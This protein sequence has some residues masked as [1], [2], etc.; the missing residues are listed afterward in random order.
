MS[1]KE[2]KLIKLVLAIRRSG[3]DIEKIYNEEVLNDD[4][5]S[6]SKM[7]TS[8]NKTSRM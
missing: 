2:S 3:V 4:S 1:D 5:V 6:E 8:M 7:P